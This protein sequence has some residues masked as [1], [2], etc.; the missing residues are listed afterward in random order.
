MGVL[1]RGRGITAASA[2]LP[3]APL[4]GGAGPPANAGQRERRFRYHWPRTPN[5]NMRSENVE[6]PGWS[7]HTR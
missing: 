5:M 3:V 2:G 6:C 7:G 4:P 1:R